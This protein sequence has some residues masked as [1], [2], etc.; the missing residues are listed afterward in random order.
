MLK[1]LT[2]LL[3]VPDTVNM[4]RTTPITKIHA[5]KALIDVLR[6]KGDMVPAS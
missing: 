2:V 5:M 4:N 6:N 3:G 1:Y